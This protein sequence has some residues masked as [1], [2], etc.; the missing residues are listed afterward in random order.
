MITVIIALIRLHASN[1]WSFINQVKVQPL[2]RV[3]LYT[4]G[5]V[6]KPPKCSYL[7]PNIVKPVA[8]NV[9]ILIILQKGK[10]IST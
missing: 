4:F 3:V 8:N 9:Y 2:V 6:I 5:N 7:Y 1:A 10:R